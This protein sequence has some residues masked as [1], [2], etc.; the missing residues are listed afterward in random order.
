MALIAVIILVGSTIE[1][2]PQLQAH[3][4][5][6][7]VLSGLSVLFIGGEVELPVAAALVDIIHR[8]AE[9]LDI[10][11]G[12]VVVLPCFTVVNNGSNL[13]GGRI[14]DADGSHGRICLQRNEIHPFTIVCAGR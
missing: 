3:Q 6:C 12:D 4:L 11:L 10:R 14:T 7:A 5:P 13:R 1:A 9:A 2:I 8:P